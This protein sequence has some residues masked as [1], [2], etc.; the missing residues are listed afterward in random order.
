MRVIIPLLAITG[1][2]ILSCEEPNINTNRLDPAIRATFIDND[3]I[4]AM[5]VTI[6]GL[7]TEIAVINDSL[8]VIDSLINAGDPNDY[9]MEIEALNAEKDAIV[10]E[11]AEVSAQ[12]SQ[13]SQGNILIDQVTAINAINDIFYDESRSIYRLPLDPG[14]GETQFFILYNGAINSATFTYE[15][16]TVLTNRTV[17]IIARELSLPTFDYDSVKFSCDTLDCSSENARVI[18]YM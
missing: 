4:V 10:D 8:E 9:T 13:V 12:L 11:R 16:D 18:F 17:K 15:T 7:T 14:N 5:E 2:F 6:D 3:S 1:F